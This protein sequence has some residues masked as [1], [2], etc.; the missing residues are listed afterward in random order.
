MPQICEFRHQIIYNGPMHSAAR[1]FEKLTDGERQAL[2]IPAILAVNFTGLVILLQVFNPDLTAFEQKTGLFSGLGVILFSWVLFRLLYPLAVRQPFL[3]WVIALVA[4]ASVVLLSVSLPPFFDTIVDIL[5]LIIVTVSA[6][7]FGR[8]PTYLFLILILIWMGVIYA[9]D[10]DGSVN[11]LIRLLGVPLVGVM[12]NETVLGLGSTIEKKVSRLEMINQVSRS[13]ATTIDVEE[14]VMQVNAAVRSALQA[15][16]YY[17]GLLHGNRI[18]L[19]LFYDDG[20]FYPKTDLSIEDTLAGWLV[21]NRKSVLFR[22]LPKEVRELNIKTKIIGKSKTSLSWMGVPMLAGNDV[23][24]IMAVAAY[25]RNA[26]KSDD[27]SMLENIAN[28][29]ALVIDNAYHHAEVVE[30]SRLDS[31]TQVYNHS[32]LLAY[33]EEYTQHARANEAHLS[34]IMLDVDHFKQYNDTYGHLVGDEALNQVVNAVRQSLRSKDVVGRWGG[35]EFAVLL[36]ETTGKQAMQVA[37]RIRQVLRTLTVLNREGQPVAVPTV[38]QG[39]AVY[40]EV[41]DALSLVDLADQRLYSAKGR[42]RDQVE[43]DAAHWENQDLV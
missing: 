5:A 25:Q 38:S 42:G 43:P 30:Q 19:E 33:L 17:V 36:P 13:L 28:Q 31:L 11:S 26:F 23:I 4:S 22:N 37:G 24:G 9:S 10:L 2:L 34:M 6:I 8:W 18:H 14:V 41:Q 27:L 29:A 15:D 7:L 16:T 35:E 1:P 39:I 32:N 21:K 20:E 3:Q 40:S 12:I